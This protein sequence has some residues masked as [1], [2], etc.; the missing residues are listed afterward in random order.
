MPRR[1]SS[2]D[3]QWLLID[4]KLNEDLTSTEHTYWGEPTLSTL[5]AYSE[6][7]EDLIMGS[8]CT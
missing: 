8:R 3:P 1:S 5:E 6:L 4:S 7:N 2:V